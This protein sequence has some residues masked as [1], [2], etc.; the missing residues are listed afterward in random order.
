MKNLVAI[1]L[2]ILS[3]FGYNNENICSVTEMDSHLIISKMKSITVNQKAIFKKSKAILGDRVKTE[4]TNCIKDKLN[5]K[6]ENEDIMNYIIEPIV[7]YIIESLIKFLFNHIIPYLN[8]LCTFIIQLI[9]KNKHL[10]LIIQMY[11]PRV[12]DSTATQAPSHL[13]R[14]QKAQNSRIVVNF[15]LVVVSSPQPPLNRRFRYVKL[16]CGVSK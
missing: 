11:F 16:A 14:K 6:I 2:L 4:I 8:C 13:V 7:D 5:D 9:G 3:I 15:E 1:L 12:T 10:Y